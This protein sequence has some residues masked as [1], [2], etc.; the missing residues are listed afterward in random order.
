[1]HAR[2]GCGLRS[3]GQDMLWVLVAFH[4]A[5]LFVFN[6]FPILQSYSSGL[7]VLGIML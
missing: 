2:C 7:V 4:L 5:N 1:M 3:D 6:F